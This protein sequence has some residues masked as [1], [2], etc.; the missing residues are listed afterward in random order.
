MITIEP[1]KLML[2]S[3]SADA[4]TA[5]IQLKSIRLNEDKTLTLSEQLCDLFHK[6][7]NIA[8]DR[9]YIEFVDAPRK[10]WGWNSSTF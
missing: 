1:T 7:I 8:K 3:D 5:F 6:K 4:P 9:I 2:F 10:M